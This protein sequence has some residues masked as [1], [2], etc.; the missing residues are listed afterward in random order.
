MSGMCY[1]FTSIADGIIS[2]TE[3]FTVNRDGFDRSK[4]MLKKELDPVITYRTPPKRLKA[5]VTLFSDSAFNISACQSYG[6]TD[7]IT[8][9]NF[10]HNGDEVN[11]FHVI[12]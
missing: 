2:T 4:G 6:Q 10:E 9:I 7:T 5:N 8:G 12:D 11:L 3:S 1:T